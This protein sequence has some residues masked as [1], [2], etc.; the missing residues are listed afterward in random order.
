MSIVER[1][2]KSVDDNQLADLLAE[3]IRIPSP[4]PPGDTTAITKRIK[5]EMEALGVEN[6]KIYER[7]KGYQSI[8]GEIGKG[9][10]PTLI[11]YAHSDVVPVRDDELTQWKVDPMAGIIEDDIIWGRGAADTKSG[12]TSMLGA[13]KALRDAQIELQGKFK[14]IAF[15]DGEGGDVEGAKYLGEEN[16]LEGDLVI[17]CEPT[18]YRLVR[19]FMG[20]VWLEVAVEGKAVHASIPHEGINA[21]EK[22]TKVIDAI[23]AHRLKW[24]TDPDL[25]DSTTTFTTIQGGSVR[26]ATA[27]HCRATFDVR[28]VPGQSVAGVIEEYT[29]LLKKLEEEDKE[30]KVTL[31]LIPTGREPVET[32]EVDYPGIA[33][34]QEAFKEVDG[35]DL[36]FFGGIESPGALVYFNDVGIPGLSFGPG[37]IRY[38][39]LANEFVEK[40][41]VGNMA[42]IYAIMATRFCGVQS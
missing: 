37:N 36:E 11:L 13:V 17:S 30:L 39:H 33:I 27:G 38:A 20:R 41:R 1:I 10:G 7:K 42:R 40:Y 22:M 29:S 35:E 31:S 9:Q 23:R 4:T 26:N 16:L 18:G 21:I 5:E 12:L 24:E 6:I 32:A 19:K 8:M 14:I 28:L 25:G 3:F 34:A 15:A 2:K